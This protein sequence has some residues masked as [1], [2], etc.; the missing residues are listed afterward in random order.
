MSKP[1]FR[2]C[3]VPVRHHKTVREGWTVYSVQDQIFEI[4]ERYEL[5]GCVGK[6]AF[7]TVVSARTCEG[8]VAIK[9]IIIREDNILEVKR[10]DAFCS[11]VQ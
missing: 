11:L 1:P 8:R 5:L 9:K 3:T 7:G 4:P 2:P 10:F 6:G